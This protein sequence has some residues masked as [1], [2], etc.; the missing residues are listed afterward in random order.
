[1]KKAPFKKRFAYWFDNRMAKGG[2]VLIR[3]LAVFTLLIVL[4]IAFI[5]FRF[6]LKEDVS[7]F[8]ALWDSFSTVINA[9]MP[10]YDDGGETVRIS[11]LIMMSI[12]AIAGLF[13]TSVLI[14]II[15]S[16][17]E[18]KITSL[19]RGTSEVIE[20]D[21]IVVL[22]FY[23]GEYTLLKQLVLAAADRPCCIVVAG[24]MEQEEM[25]QYIKDNVECPKDGGYLRSEG[26]GALLHPYLPVRYH[27]P[28]R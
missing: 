24:D 15:S 10:A 28:D 20:E 1:M 21:H 16:A 3:L 12:A 7:F 23:P 2:F 18:E 8:S 4:L 25:Q 14:G 22:G 27:Q 17:I 9:W 11:Y 26:S 13:I 5:V 6:S 19:K